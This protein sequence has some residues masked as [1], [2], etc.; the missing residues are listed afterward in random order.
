MQNYMELE[1]IRCGDFPEIV[2]EV[3]GTPNGQEIAPLLLLPLIENA[4]KH[5]IEKRSDGVP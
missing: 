5:G 3:K 2:L 1:K 4:F